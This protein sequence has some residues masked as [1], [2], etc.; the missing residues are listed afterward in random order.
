[1]EL[2]E[3]LTDARFEF[4]KNWDDF[5]KGVTEEHLSESEKSLKNLL[6]VETLAGQ[7]FLDIGSGSGLFS[8]SA[9][10][11]GAEVVSFDYDDNSVQC[12]SKLKAR[13]FPQSAKWKIVQGSILDRQ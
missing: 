1:M 5:L 2:D 6:G 10:R 4:G 12:A 8:L 13:Y 7:R 3:K 9:M 11:L